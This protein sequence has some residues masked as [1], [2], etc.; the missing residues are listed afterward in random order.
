VTFLQLPLTETV[1][2]GVAVAQVVSAMA[3]LVRI[4]SSRYGR[5]FG[6]GVRE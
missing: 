3:K 2:A 6:M 1:L 4:R 5:G